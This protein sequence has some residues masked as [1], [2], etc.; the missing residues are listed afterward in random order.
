MTAHLTAKIPRLTAKIPR[1]VEAEKAARTLRVKAELNIPFPVKVPTKET[2]SGH[3]HYRLHHHLA[4]LTCNLQLHHG[5]SHQMK[6]PFSQS[7]RK[8]QAMMHCLNFLSDHLIR[9]PIRPAIDQ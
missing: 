4:M 1:Q 2:R 9:L 7:G 8:K 3:H 5:Y 6:Q